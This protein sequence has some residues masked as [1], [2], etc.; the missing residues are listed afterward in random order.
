MDLCYASVKD[1]Y[2]ACCMELF[3]GLK[4]GATCSNRGIQK[5]QCRAIAILLHSQVLAPMLSLIIAGCTLLKPGEPPNLGGWRIV[6]Q[7]DEFTDE[8]DCMSTN[9]GALI[10]NGDVM[11][12]GPTLF[13]RK[14]VAFGPYTFQYRLDDEPP[15]YGYVSESKG[16]YLPVSLIAGKG[17]KRLRVRMASSQMQKEDNYDLAIDGILL[18]AEAVKKCSLEVSGR[19]KG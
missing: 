2:F 10:Y 19:K 14:P 7:T 11:F 5:R 18:A 3:A 16:G 12:S 9:E 4:H 1:I 15:G 13:F 8:T 17:F 6:R